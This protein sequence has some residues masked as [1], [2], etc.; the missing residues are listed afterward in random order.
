[1]GTN[2]IRAACC[3]C[4]KT[5]QWPGR[6]SFPRQKTCQFQNGNEKP[7]T[8]GCDEKCTHA[9][10]FYRVS[11]LV[12]AALM[13]HPTPPIRI[14]GAIH[15]FLLPVATYCPVPGKTVLISL[16]AKPYTS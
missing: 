4:K 8:A 7:G 16:L 10:P 14:Q 6:L 1:M 9:T 5:P 3:T 2:E 15:L 13:T 11:W 12:R